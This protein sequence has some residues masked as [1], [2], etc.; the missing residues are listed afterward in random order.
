MTLTVSDAKIPVK[1]KHYQTLDQV[2]AH[3]EIETELAARLHKSTKAERRHLYTAVYNE[4]YTKLPNNSIA[5][6]KTSLATKKWVI[7]QR[8]Q[9]IQPFLKPDKVFLEIGPGDC[10]LCFEIARQVKQVYAVDV[11]EQYK[12]Q[13]NCPDNFKLI[14]SDGTSIPVPDNSIDIIYS[15]QVMEHL[16]PEDA[17]E[18]LQNIYRALAP[19][20]IY[21][22]ITPN[23]LS[24]PHDIS[25]HFDEIST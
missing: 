2:K 11:T 16:H 20:G 23:R 10:G 12:D 5:K 9:F 4:L 18:Q 19:G 7:Q 13:D 17:V 8:L 21:I 24:G 15:H 3:Y 1:D 14:I 22:C 6:R 25:H